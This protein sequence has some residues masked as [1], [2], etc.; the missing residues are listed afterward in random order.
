MGAD[1]GF[2]KNVDKGQ[3]KLENT[4]NF[5]VAAFYTSNFADNVTLNVNAGYTQKLKKTATGNK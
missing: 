2:S 1:Y 5:G 4:N 3:K